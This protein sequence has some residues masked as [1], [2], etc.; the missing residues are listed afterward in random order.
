MRKEGIILPLVQ[1]AGNEKG[2][3]LMTAHGSKGL[4]FDYVFVAGC[5]SSCWEKNANHSADLLSP[6]RFL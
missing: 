6:I 4:E 1:V 2:V 3:N 5:S